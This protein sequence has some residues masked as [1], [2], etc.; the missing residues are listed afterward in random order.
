M[1]KI[2]NTEVV[3]WE[4]AI[5]EMRYS[6]ISWGKSDSGMCPNGTEFG[7]CYLDHRKYCPRRNTYDPAFCI[8]SKDLDLMMLLR[9]TDTDNRKFMQMITVYLDITAPL[10]WW[11]EFDTHKIDRFL[12]YILWESYKCN[13]PRLKTESQ[14]HQNCWKTYGQC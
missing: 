7:H 10:Y 1:L 9:N 12:P 5:R 13:A 3:G 14:R 4:A 11:K 2:E 6:K 8:G